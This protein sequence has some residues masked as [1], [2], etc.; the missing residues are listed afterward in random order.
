[1]Q[2]N[3][4]TMLRLHDYLL[5][6]MQ[7]PWARTISKAIL[8]ACTAAIGLWFAYFAFETLSIP[9]PLEYRESAS[10][11]MTQYLLAGRNPYGLENQPMAMDS[12]GILY[13]L[14]VLPLAA[15]FGNT[16][17]IHRV[18][19]LVFLLLCA[20][21]VSWTAYK[22]SKSVEAA[23]AFGV[24]VI[25]VLGARAGLGAFPSAIGAFCY[26]GALVIPA[27]RSFDRAGLMLSAFLSLLAYYSKPYFLLAF[28]IVASYLFLFVSKKKGALYALGF[29]AAAVASFL[30]VRALLPVYFVYTIGNNLADA[31]N[32]R[33]WLYYQ[34]QQLWREFYPSIILAGLLVLLEAAAYRTV[35]RAG[36]GPLQL[37]D[38]R[39]AERPLISRPLNYFAYMRGWAGIVFLALLG[40]NDGSW[41]LYAYQLVMPLFYLWV[42]SLF[43]PQS[44]LALIGI[45]LLALNMASFAAARF[46]PS[47]LQQ[48]DSAGWAR[49]YQYTDSS[50]HLLNTPIIA[51]EMVRLGMAPVDTGRNSFWGL[52]PYPDIG[53]IGPSYAQVVRAWGGY[54]DSIQAAVA[55]RAYDRI[56]TIPDRD[57]FKPHNLRRYYTQV[58]S[59]NVTMPQTDQVWTVQIWEPVP[60]S[61]G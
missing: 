52:K 9:Y 21:L 30:L 32:D 35:A 53:L 1:M 16:L 39:I 40:H 18:V 34:L 36:E 31:M 25:M 43:K 3:P 23:I 37:A 54:Q 58:D 4:T 5:G 59:L 57:F 10:Q 60:G 19:S 17:L 55:S 51:S 47:F 28:P 20:V 33:A 22:C 45:P 15:V 46:A 27:W 2:S 24:L 41:M 14:V 42:A 8:V 56:I 48:R 44:R 50:K 26:L 12:Y 49:L 11:V 61:G 29:A 6:D 13:S 7:H 38:I